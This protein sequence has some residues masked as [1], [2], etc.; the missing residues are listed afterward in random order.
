MNLDLYSHTAFALE[1]SGAAALNLDEVQT[2]LTVPAPDRTQRIDGT[3]PSRVKLGAPRDAR[4]WPLHV[5]IL[6]S[7]GEGLMITF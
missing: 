7:P 6:L 4:A 5:G 3:A 2:T 1:G